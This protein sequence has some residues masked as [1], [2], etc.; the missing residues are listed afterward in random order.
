[1]S[2]IV[3]QI[4]PRI[5]QVFANQV[6]NVILGDVDGTTYLADTVFFNSCAFAEVE[7]NESVALDEEE[8][9]IED[10]DEEEL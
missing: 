4:F 1:M 5:F 7:R 10:A 9:K 3:R 6:G 2:V 8:V